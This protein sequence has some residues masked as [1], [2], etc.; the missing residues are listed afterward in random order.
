MRITPYEI[1]I[2]LQIIRKP[3][4]IIVFLFTW[5]NSYFKNL[6]TSVD[7]KFFFFNFIPGAS[8]LPSLFLATANV[9][10]ILISAS[11]F[12][13]NIRGIWVILILFCWNHCNLKWSLS[14]SLD[15]CSFSHRAFSLTWRAST[16]IY[17]KKESV[18][19]RKEF[20]SH[21]IGLEYTNMAAASFFG[22]T[23]WPPWRHVKT[24]Y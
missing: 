4:P 14:F 10:Q 15:Q 8:Q 9:F 2:I 5:N 17:W 21:R 3:N 24:L 22:T 16:P 6:N 11:W 18:Y 23:I 20:N 13:R 7:V 19:I 12:W 1:W